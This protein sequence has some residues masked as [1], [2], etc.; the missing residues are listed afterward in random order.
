MPNAF[1]F[2]GKKVTFLA[3]WQTNWREAI[4]SRFVIVDNTS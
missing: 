4:T 3:Q 2:L 1:F